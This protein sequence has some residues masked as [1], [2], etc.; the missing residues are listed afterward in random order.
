MEQEEGSTA[1]VEER[2]MCLDNADKSLQFKVIS[3]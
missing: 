2:L 1:L 3:L